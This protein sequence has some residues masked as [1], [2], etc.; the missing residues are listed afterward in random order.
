MNLAS[1]ESDLHFVWL[2]YTHLVKYHGQV[3]LIFNRSDMALNWYIIMYIVVNI[4][5]DGKENSMDVKDATCIHVLMELVG[6]FKV[7]TSDITVI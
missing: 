4:I 1:K 6:A 3:Y 7:Y 2:I 5:M